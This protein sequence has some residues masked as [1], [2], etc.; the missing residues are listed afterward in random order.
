MTSPC[1]SYKLQHHGCLCHSSGLAPVYVYVAGQASKAI[2]GL[3]L[4]LTCDLVYADNPSSVMHL[5]FANS[6]AVKNIT[7][8]AGASAC[9]DLEFSDECVWYRT[10]RH[11]KDL[12]DVQSLQ[13]PATLYILHGSMYRSQLNMP[14]SSH[15]ARPQGSTASTCSIHQRFH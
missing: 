9:F 8:L 2:F 12:A 14:C 1:A 5:C 4:L 3:R 11:L 10:C 13:F 7:L 15:E 6:L